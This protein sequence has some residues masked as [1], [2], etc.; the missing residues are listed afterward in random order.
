MPQLV[1]KIEGEILQYVINDINYIKSV[2]GIIQDSDYI[3]LNGYI[4][5]MQNFVN[6]EYTQLLGNPLTYGLPN[7]NKLKIAT[8]EI[9]Y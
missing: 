5:Y 4:A 8:I 9:D 7:V 3:Y 2:S 6:V 1:Q